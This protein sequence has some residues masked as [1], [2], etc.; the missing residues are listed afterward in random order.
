LLTLRQ[1]NQ[2]ER[3]QTQAIVLD[4]QTGKVLWTH[5]LFNTRSRFFR[6]RIAADGNQFFLIDKIPHWQ[7]WV[8]QMN[9]HWYLNRSVTV[10]K[11]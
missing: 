7:L 1:V 9:R 2:D 8:L 11:N 5:T 4:R 10:E 3:L 6:S